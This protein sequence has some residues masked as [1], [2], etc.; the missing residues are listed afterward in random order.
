MFQSKIYYPSHNINILN[1]DERNVL[2]SGGKIICF[3]AIFIYI[4]LLYV[5]VCLNLNDH[6]ILHPSQT[7]ERNSFKCCV[8][9][10]RQTILGA[11]AMVAMQALV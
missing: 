2:I 5:Y 10:R 6:Q 4:C 3:I 9:E 8:S 11:R 7:T 1:Y